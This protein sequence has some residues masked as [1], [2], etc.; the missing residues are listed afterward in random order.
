MHLYPPSRVKD[1]KT[2]YC[3]MRRVLQQLMA[4]AQEQGQNINYVIH[5]V[6][7]TVYLT[8]ITKLFTDGP[9]Q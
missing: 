3:L 5:K 8:I 6:P 9:A 7:L 4:R 1:N 2:V